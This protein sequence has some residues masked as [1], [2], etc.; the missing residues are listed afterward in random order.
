MWNGFSWVWKGDCQMLSCCPLMR[1]VKPQFNSTCFT[2]WSTNRRLFKRS[3]NHDVTKLSFQNRQ[4]GPWDFIQWQE[5]V[6]HEF[7]R[8]CKRN[9]N[10][11]VGRRCKQ[12]ALFVRPYTNAVVQRRLEN[13]PKIKLH[14]NWKFYTVGVL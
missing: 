13:K 8:K 4:K 5:N 14:H 2:L 7:V 1:I 12:I 3:K 6:N 10:I 11:S 9:L